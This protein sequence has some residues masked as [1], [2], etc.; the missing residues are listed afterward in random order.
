MARSNRTVKF[1]VP[2]QGWNA[3]DGLDAMAELDAVV[4][5]NIYPAEGFL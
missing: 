5:D 1:Q 3:R 2:T 4:M